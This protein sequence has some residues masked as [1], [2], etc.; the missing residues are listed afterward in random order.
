M[1]GIQ[2]L[3]VYPTLPPYF[4]GLPRRSN[5]T[6]VALHAKCAIML[7]ILFVAADTGSRQHDL[8][9]NRGVVAV[10]ALKI[11][12]FSI[13]FEAGFIVIEIPVFPV[14]GVVAG[15]TSRAQRALVGILLF[16]A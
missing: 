3:V 11:L 13:Q 1:S 10:D 8:G 4:D 12:V 9:S 6:M 2:K 15:F 5:M 7:I 14:A 16:M